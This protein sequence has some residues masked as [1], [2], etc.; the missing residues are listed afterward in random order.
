MRLRPDIEHLDI[1]TVALLEERERGA[2]VVDVLRQ[3]TDPV[4]AKPRDAELLRELFVM[5]GV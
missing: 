2:G 1:G 5:L 3:E 4:L